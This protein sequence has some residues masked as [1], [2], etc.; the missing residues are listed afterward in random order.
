MGYSDIN[1]GGNRSFRI[2]YPYYVISELSIIT[3][4]NVKAPVSD[5]ITLVPS[6][7]NS[8]SS[9]NSELNELG[10]FD[11]TVS[12]FPVLRRPYSIAGNHHHI[13]LSRL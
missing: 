5:Q 11:S 7:L 4:A 12:H 2:G 1:Y 6:G 9:E 10:H 8:T 13:F 3:S